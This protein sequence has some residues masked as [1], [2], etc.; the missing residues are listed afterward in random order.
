MNL[1]VNILFLILLF[2]PLSHAQSLIDEKAISGITSEIKNTELIVQAKLLKVVYFAMDDDGNILG[3]EYANEDFGR[4]KYF[5]QRDGSYAK[6]MSIATFEICHYLKGIFQTNEIEV[7]T[8]HIWARPILVKLPGRSYSI[9]IMENLLNQF[10]PFIFI[11]RGLVDGYFI[12]PIN[13]SSTSNLYRI[14]DKMGYI[15]FNTFPRADF[16]EFTTSNT[17]LIGVLSNGRFNGY[18]ELIDFLSNFSDY[19]DVQIIDCNGDR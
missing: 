17:G 11:G 14:N 15:Y 10:S 7:R 18:D 4:I 16:K 13:K 6:V 5:H 1:R 9:D 2:G 3:N 12:L 8:E 19:L